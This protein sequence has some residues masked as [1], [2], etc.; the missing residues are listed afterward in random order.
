MHEAGHHLE[1]PRCSLTAW[2]ALTTGLVSV[3]VSQ[4]LNRLDRVRRLVHHNHGR[5]SKAGLSSFEIVKVSEDRVADVL[6]EHRGRGAAGDDGEEVIPSATDAAGM[7]LDELLQAH[8]HL[9]LDDA[10]VVHMARDGEKLCPRVVLPPE[11][12]EPR[13][14]TTEDLWCHRDGLDVGD[15]GGTTEDA[16]GGWEGRLEAWFA[17]L[18]FEGLNEACLLATNVSTGTAVEVDIKGHPGATSILADVATGIGLLDSS[19]KDLGLV[20]E[21]ATDVNVS[22]DSSHGCPGDKAT[23]NETMRI[24]SHDLTILAGT[25]LGLIGIHDEIR[26]TTARCDRPESFNVRGRRKI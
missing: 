26:W 9:L 4:T 20:D 14:A 18:A 13:A 17:H 21:L 1:E 25:W 22:A 10:R 19:L 16:N 2:G 8:R 7:N 6:R 24:G 15:G 3:E 23:L 12:G 5:R 11:T